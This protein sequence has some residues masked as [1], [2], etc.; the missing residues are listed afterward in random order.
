MKINLLRPS[1]LEGL[2]TTWARP[3]L[4]PQRQLIDSNPCYVTA[5]GGQDVI[6]LSSLDLCR[7]W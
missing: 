2:S 7:H 3:N 5:S 1:W 4:P 6:M